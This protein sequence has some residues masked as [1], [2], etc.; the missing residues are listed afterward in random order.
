MTLDPLGLAGINEIWA[1]PWPNIGINDQME[2]GNAGLAWLVEIDPLDIEPGVQPYLMTAGGG[3]GVL[4]WVGLGE[5]FELNRY[6]PVPLDT[7]RYTTLAG[8]MVT[9]A[10][11]EPADT[12]VDGRL[13]LSRIDVRRQLPVRDRF[14]GFLAQTS[15]SVALDGGDGLLDGLLTDMVLRDRPIR[16]KVAPTTRT[17]SG[18]EA[19]PPLAD[20]TTAFAGLIAGLALD[21]DGALTLQIADIANRLDRPIQEHLY[22]GTGG[23]EGGPELAGVPRPLNYGW[24]RAATPTAVDQL[25]LIYQV[26]DGEVLSAL[27]RDRG[28]ALIL[29]RDVATYEQLAA[30]TVA[31]QADEPDIDV[32]QFATCRAQGFFRLGSTP[33]GQLTCDVEGDGLH[34]G[35]IKFDGGV[36]FDGG[37]GFD[38][39]GA[40]TYNRYAGGMLFRILTTR[41]YVAPD[42]IDLDRIRQFDRENPFEL[43]LSIPSSERP[44]VRA[45]CTAIADS[46]GAVILRTQAGR[47]VLRAL[48]GPA[49]GSALN[50]GRFGDQDARRVQATLAPDGLER[51][52]LPWGAPWAKARTRYDVTWAPQATDDVAADATD[53]ER[54]AATRPARYASAEDAALAAILPDR[55]VLELP[56]LLRHRADAVTVAARVRDFYAH[57]WTLWR[58]TCRGLSSRLDPLDTVR[59]IHPRFGLSGGRNL[60]VVG[61]QERPGRGETELTLFG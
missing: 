30:L 12:W 8:G 39:P 26:H 46:V 61:V 54:E 43:G 20:F 5:V 38:A 3:L 56:T 44:T 50:I 22:T 21:G 2:G 60:L 42:G 53:D 19:P 28:Q 52:P 7:L 16:I 45:V 58:A 57:G 1:Y 29:V 4:G 10:A 6:K 11:D 17:V 41:G 9:A 55:E 14:S 25:L 51:L 23:R 49:R 35:P 15:A 36:L 40:D 47:I 27:P 48:I 59:V 31:G 33:L 34:D 13:K 24:V 32:G 18:S 37:I